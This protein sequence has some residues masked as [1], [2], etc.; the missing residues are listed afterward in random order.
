[1]GATAGTLSRPAT[2]QRRG[3]V[4]GELP[5]FSFHQSNA[6]EHSHTKYA[7]YATTSRHRSE[8]E[9]ARLKGEANL[10]KEVREWSG[11]PCNAYDG[12]NGPPGGLS[13]G[14]RPHSAAPRGKGALSQET[15]RVKTPLKNM[16]RCSPELPVTFQTIQHPEA[17]AAQPATAPPQPEAQSLLAGG[18]EMWSPPYSKLVADITA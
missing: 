12:G 4:V 14:W 15:I 1:M 17:G 10:M 5:H 11:A 7:P 16:S 9:Q 6:G 8:L 3:E 2:A 13:S 18:S